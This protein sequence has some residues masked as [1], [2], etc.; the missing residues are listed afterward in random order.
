[1]ESVSIVLQFYEYWI[2]TQFLHSSSTVETINPMYS[3][4][5]SLPHHLEVEHILKWCIHSVTTV[6]ISWLKYEV[7]LTC[8][9]F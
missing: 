1:M 4:L 2:P 5:P 6:Q 8:V 7:Q 3:V 9:N